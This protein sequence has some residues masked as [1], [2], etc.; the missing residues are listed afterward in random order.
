MRKPFPVA[1]LMPLLLAVLFITAGTRPLSAGAESAK[2]PDKTLSPYFLVK[3]DDPGK[4]QLP[5]KA[6][7]ADV[8]IAGVVAEVKITQV[9]QNR[10]KKTLEAIYVFPA[11]TRAA[12]HAMR[13]TVGKRVVVAQI[14]ER[15]KARETY[16]QAKKEGKTTSLLEQQRP[17]VFQMNV[18]NILPGDEVKVELTYLELLV[19]ENRIYE[20][21]FPTV[22]GPRYSNMKE[23]GAPETERWVKNPYLHEGQAPPFSYDI[24]VEING[25]L[26]LSKLSC[27]SH[28]IEVKYPSPNSARISLKDPATGGTKD[29]V[30]R[31]ALGGDRI[32]SGLLM[33]PGKDDNFFLLMMEPPARV[34][35]EAVVKRE[36][37]FI[38]DI[39][40]SMHGFPLDTTKTL[41]ADIING[42][43]PHDFLNVLLFEGKPEV[44]SASG[45]LAATPENKKQA[46]GFIKGQSG[47]GGTEILTALKQAL[48][49]PRTPGTSRIVVVATDGYVHVEPQTFELIRQNLGAA[50]LFAFGIGRGVNRHL[51]EGMARAGQGEPFVVLNP[52]EA[53]KLAAR[54][55]DYIESP[56]LTNIKV[57]FEGFEV[58]DLEPPALPD[59][60]AQRPLTLLGKYRGKPTGAIVVTGKTAKGEFKQEI[61]V[62][63]KEASPDNAALR[64]L[65]A[66][67]RLMRLAD[68]TRLDRGKDEARIK[69][70]TA[71]GLKYSLMS[72]YTS[73]VAVDKVKRADGKLV[74]VKQ[75]LPLP[76]G[77]SDLAVG[78]GG[79][80]GLSGGRIAKSMAPFYAAASPEAYVRASR[81]ARVHPTPPSTAV[82]APAVKIESVQ[83]QGRLDRKAVQEALEANLYRLT[84][85]CQDS[86][87]KGIKLPAAVI[88]TFKVGAGGQ[89]SG[90]VLPKMPL[91]YESLTKCLSQVVKT[92]TFPDPGKKTAT[93]TVKLVLGK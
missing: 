42:L 33:Y 66:R 41:M 93:V 23:A 83:V 89:V 58:L 82:Q 80:Y 65:W 32:H 6:T 13:M 67:Q 35:P 14:M 28:D 86:L 43:K 84:A 30:L 45:S 52:G 1:P 27:P 9:Y 17:N 12:V 39:S 19:P 50:N 59:L 40:G 87:K 8:K 71:L 55:R 25:G 54:F 22:V 21:V 18:A 60:F 70:I 46:L 76:E 11:S 3:T 53:P 62:D 36:Y 16:E 69:E 63:A 79:R 5:L 15:Q 20:F 48:N 31:Y 2:V 49:L 92:I 64:L 7:K 75:P 81:P 4:D 61:K 34:K 91:G 56:L 57:S 68:L 73:F 72:P 90:P 51:I 38:V 24:K 37:I 26:P 88:L 77:V 29:F 74:T 85:C 47:G 44:L 10:G 78:G